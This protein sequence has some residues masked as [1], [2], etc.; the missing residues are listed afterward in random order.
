MPDRFLLALRTASPPRQVVAYPSELVER[1]ED[2]RLPDDGRPWQVWRVDVPDGFGAPALVD[3]LEVD[4]LGR[5][6][7]SMTTAAPDTGP[8]PTLDELVDT[9][10]ELED[11]QLEELRAV[12]WA[13]LDDDGRR[14][15]LELQ[16]RKTARIVEGLR[17]GSAKARQLLGDWFGPGG[18]P[19]LQPDLAE[20][21]V[22]AYQSPD[23]VHE[24]ADAERAPLEACPCDVCEG[25]A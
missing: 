17:R 24:L 1:V 18:R 10:R 19:P 3:V 16:D 25:R 2:V 4:V 22:V 11:L 6:F 9:K 8:P 15:L 7:A 12:G 23:G 21:R 14:R 5:L 13:Q 20:L